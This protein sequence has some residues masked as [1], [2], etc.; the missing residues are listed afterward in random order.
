MS[1][2]KKNMPDEIGAWDETPEILFEKGIREGEWSTE[3]PFEDW[4]TVYV[5]CTPARRH[6]D[7]LAEALR[8]AKRQI[9]YLH[10]KFQETGSGSAVLSRISQTLAKLEET[11]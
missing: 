11:P 6:A 4:Q 7:E 10:G 3:E 2:Y 5:V 1:G 8:E 9:E